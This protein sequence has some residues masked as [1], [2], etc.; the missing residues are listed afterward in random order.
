VSQAHTDT[1]A[2][3][4]IGEP[5]LA[6]RRRLRGQAEPRREH[7]G[8]ERSAAAPARSRGVLGTGERAR[9]AGGRRRLAR[10]GARCGERSPAAA[11]SIGLFTVGGGASGGVYSFASVPAGRFGSTVTLMSASPMKPVSSP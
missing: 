6:L 7:D 5:R 1:G 9:R 3:A 10:R 2:E 11:H 8:D 4:A